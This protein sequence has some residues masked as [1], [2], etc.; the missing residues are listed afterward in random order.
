MQVCADGHVQAGHLS[1]VESPKRSIAGTH[2]GAEL[3]RKTLRCNVTDSD[4][5]PAVP[6]TVKV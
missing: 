4:S 5:V 1:P 3:K 2:F 6:V